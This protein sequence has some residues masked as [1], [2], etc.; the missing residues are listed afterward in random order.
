MFKTKSMIVELVMKELKK[1][2]LILFC[3]TIIEAKSQSA[4]VAGLFP[5]ID[6][7]AELS[8]KFEYG[9][10]YFIASPLVKLNQPNISQDAH[11]L[12][13]YSEQSLSYKFNTRFSLTGSYVFQRENPFSSNYT[14][15]NRFY[16]QGTYKHTIKALNVK[17]RVRFDGRFIHN[18]ITNVNPFTQRVRYLI[19][20]DMPIKSQ[21]NNLYFTIYEEAF[22]NTFS[23]NTV[24]AYA[25]NWAYAALGIKLNKSNKIELGLLYI[26]WKTDANSWF[27]QYYL[28]VSWVNHLDFR[29]KQDIEIK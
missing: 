26:S 19:G 22:L 5:T 13:F 16:L 11:T 3:F 1:G 25:E 2:I 9:L 24:V 12:L 6:H 4:S 20:L 18:K 10:Y 14:N 27:N 28:Q 29:K 21:K 17:H 23:K 8:N 15:E 7:S